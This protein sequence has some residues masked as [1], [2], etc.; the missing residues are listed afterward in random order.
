VGHIGEEINRVHV[1]V[2]RNLRYAVKIKYIRNNKENMKILLYGLGRMGRSV[3]YALT[4][5]GHEVYGIDINEWEVERAKQQGLQLGQEYK[6]CLGTSLDFTSGDALVSCLPYY[7]NM[8]L[9]EKCV[10]NNIP[11]FDLGGH[12]PSSVEI[13]NMGGTV[14]TDLGLAPGLVNI[15]G[16]D[17]AKYCDTLEMYCGGL[18]QEPKN[19]LSYSLTWSIDGLLNEYTDKA[20]IKAEGNI[21]EVDSLDGYKNVYWDR[22]VEPYES[23]Y[24]SGAMNYASSDIPN[25]SYRTIRYKGHRDLIKWLI[26]IL[27]NPYGRESLEALIRNGC[28]PAPD[29]VLIKC[30]SKNNLDTEYGRVVDYKGNLEVTILPLHNF[31]AMQVATGF[32][33]AA[34][35]DQ[36]LQRGLKGTLGYKDVD[37]VEL[38]KTLDILGVKI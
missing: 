15:L 22:E 10:E 23:F 24:T 17:L 3:L 34:V 37:I 7:L 4:K 5:L 6:L 18:P 16:E 29:K 8:G 33:L 14:F 30:L 20:V 9:A 36:V 13:N 31:S 35:V 28:P 32:S 1:I 12:I 27:N 19:P 26:E 38:K 25:V 11:Y 21:I 2:E